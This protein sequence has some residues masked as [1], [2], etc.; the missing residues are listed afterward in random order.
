MADHL[1]SLLDEHWNKLEQEVASAPNRLRTSRL[2]SV[3]D[4][5]SLNAAMDHE[6][7]RHLLVPLSSTQHVRTSGD[8]SALRLR[9]RPLEDEASYV[10]YADLCCTR[11][12]LNDVFTSLCVD[13]LQAVEAK[14]DRPLKALYSVLNRWRSLFQKSS[15]ELGPEQLAGLFGE[16]LVL[17]RLL[18]S[19]PTATDWWFG[20]NGARHD[21]VAEGHAI[22]VKSSLAP[23]ERR[24]RVHG[25][26]QLEVPAGGDLDLVWFRLS[27]SQGQGAGLLDLLDQIRRLADD[28][29][30]FFTKL[31]MVGY[32][33]VDADLYRDVRFIVHEERWYEIDD[34]FPRVRS[35]SIPE[36]VRDVHYTVDLDTV[37][38]QPLNKSQIEDRLAEILRGN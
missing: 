8:G 17:K 19:W 22:E 11:T 21:F 18:E 10:R 3:S 25:A 4:N 6:G 24:F 31:S 14:P 30:G 23:E 34:S 27:R 15:S 37:A 7:L 1:R 33:P 2:P 5:G 32:R 13:V 29:S 36:S 12:D 38:T 20:P 16:L 35:E 9:E 26:A 28:E